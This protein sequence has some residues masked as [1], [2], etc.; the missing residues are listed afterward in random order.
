MTPFRS[1]TAEASGNRVA[2]PTDA[3]APP[4]RRYLRDSHTVELDGPTSARILAPA[5]P[6]PP[7]PRLGTAAL[8]VLVA[9]RCATARPRLALLAPEA[10]APVELS[11]DLADAAD[12]GAVAEHPDL[13]RG[14][15]CTGTVPERLAIALV[16][17]ASGGGEAAPADFPEQDTV[18]RLREQGGRLSLTLDW[19]SG[20]FTEDGAAEL[21][22]HWRGLLLDVAE[23]PRTPTGAE[24]AAGAPVSAEPHAG[25]PGA[26]PRGRVEKAVAEIWC[27]VL[28]TE[29]LGRD[30]NF[31]AEGGGS[32]H[33]LKA[34]RRMESR[35]RVAV[36]AALLFEAPTVEEAARSVTD[37]WDEARPAP[38]EAAASA[39]GGGAPPSP[40][41]AAEGGA[42]AAQERIWFF[43]HLRPGT[44]GYNM[45]WAVDVDGALDTEALSRAVRTVV[46]RHEALR[47]VFRDDE[48]RPV[49][50]VRREARVEVRTHTV[51]ADGPDAPRAAAERLL[52]DLA[53]EPFSLVGEVLMRVDAVTL[54][55][56]EHTVLVTLHHM[57]AD[58]ASITV[59]LDE[60]AAF[61]AEET[62]GAAAGLPRAPGYAETIERRRD[63]LRDGGRDRALA[64]WRR[65]LAGAPDRIAIPFD[66][67]P[68]P[69]QGAA[70][71]ALPFTLEPAVAEAARTLAAKS[72]TT[73]FAVLM[74]A[75]QALLQRWTGEEDIVIGTTVGGRAAEGGQGV[76]GP[77]FNTVPI[78]TGHG[79]SASFG[80]AV[81]A[82]H[83]EVASALEHQEL[84]FDELVAE[85][86]ARRDP[87]R[88][89]LV[90]VLFELDEVTGRREPVPGTVWSQRLVDTGTAK[91]ELTL[92][93]TDDGER[94]RGR[95]DH[96]RS[97]A[98]E[99]ARW[100]AEAYTALLE[101][102][103]AAPDRPIQRHPLGEPPRT[104]AAAKTHARAAGRPSEACVHALFEAQADRTPGAVAVRSASTEWTYE[105]LDARANRL[106]H[107]LIAAGAGPETAVGVCLG[108]SEHMPVALL[109]V[110]KAG[111]AYVPID[112]GYPEAR[113]R[114]MLEQV[115]APILVNEDGGRADWFD[116]AV[117][118]AS[119]APAGTAPDHR[120]EVRVAPRNPVYVIYTSGSTGRPKAVVVE[121]RTVANYLAWAVSDYV[122]PRTG[123]APLFSSFA[124]DMIV[125][126]I[127]APLLTGQP[128]HVVPEDTP[129]EKLAEALMEH[130]P[131][132]FIKLTPGHL[133]LLAEFLEPDQARRLCGLLAVGAD[134]FPRQVLDRWRAL[135]PATPVLNEYGPTEASVGNCVHFVTAEEEGET[136][137]I[138]LP[139]PDTTMYVLDEAMLPV[140]V[141]GEGELYIGGAC[142]VRG[143]GG[144]QRLTADRFVPDMF[145]A[146]GGRLYRT[147]DLGRRR[148]DG[149]LEFHGR[150]DDQVKI[151]GYRVEPGEVESAIA[152]HPDVA[153]AVVA[154]AGAP[155]G[156]RLLG[157]Y[158]CE[159]PLEASEVLEHLR[160]RLPSHLLPAALMQID[161]VPL[162]R[163]GK[164]DRSALPSPA[165]AAHAL[166]GGRPGA[167]EDPVAAA[168][169]VLMAGTLGVP[170]SAVG[171]GDDFFAAGGRSLDAVRLAGRIRRAL[172]CR[173]PISDFMLDPTPR[174]IAR[175]IGAGEEVSERARRLVDLSAL[176]A[177]DR[178]SLKRRA[179]AAPD[180]EPA[181]R[182]PGE[183]GGPTYAVV[184]NA[185]GQ[186][187]VW[188]VQRPVPEGWRAEGP[189][190][191]REQCL[192]HIEAVWADMRPLSAR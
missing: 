141:G 70:G 159:R 191:T 27:S 30:A 53:A 163:N 92:T 111:A 162:N 82:A 190:G 7:L 86:G 44:P 157:Y 188:P 80:A 33:A 23:R 150:L 148:P 144:Q 99:T 126:N 49:P 98:P 42:S 9:R 110:M 109:A 143:Y 1:H 114:F 118:G 140:P 69:H 101:E 161:A 36:P 87:S 55:P 142:V 95:V 11:V 182:T 13:D 153:K 41:E 58:G 192:D 105:E 177:Q 139:I 47:T 17:E 48:G 149:N 185:E 112:P 155:G 76:V 147:G 2:L 106:A 136:L 57:V 67:P 29:S 4:L 134:T 181:P 39:P 168:V 137:P 113:K 71:A 52:R 6:R 173:L 138:G 56:R 171:S 158:V 107:L 3:P 169:A 145:G 73:V 135:D 77:L 37:L 187:S 119:R 183:G 115:S 186:Y 54:S 170:S 151:N 8:L 22:D 50:E 104:G 154:V 88:P 43:E 21:L 124:F 63:R 90:Q 179:S 40:R 122:G 15:A 130:A 20:L 156:R 10:P 46:Q 184:V 60:L 31:F 24:E 172:R 61:Y 45:P 38:E 166:D 128:V 121:H 12:L 102:A 65:R 129:P 146:P 97:L 152:D 132:A 108:R 127:Y 34:A 164:V 74:A 59:I 176:P 116:G 81:E 131:Y 125:P 78:R 5:P 91:Y 160:E 68:S 89:P 93:V 178:A 66:V 75:F 189:Q 72:G 100:L 85:L 26:P 117:L 51:G 32:L 84:P 133:D 103:C 79:R 175:A 165:S 16:V 28:G 19:E 14:R 25:A 123:G 180:G 62:G 64:H 96:S 167:G 83:R 174:G 120:P 94:L 35:F 18:F